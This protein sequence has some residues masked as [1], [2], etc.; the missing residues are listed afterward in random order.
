M[1]TKA[2]TYHQKEHWMLLKLL[3]VIFISVVPAGVLA[4]NINVCIDDDWFP[5]TFKKDGKAV[6]VHVDIVRKATEDLG[7]TVDLQPLPWKRCLKL[8]Q[9][10]KVD[11]V[12]SASYKDKRAAY[13]YYPNDVK[14]AKK[15]KG[16][17]DQV[18][19]VL[20]TRHNDPYEFNGDWST[21]PQPVGVG[22]LG[23]SITGTLEK[24]GLHVTE[25]N[26]KTG[27]LSMLVIKRV[28][29]VSLNPI[30]A[31]YFNTTGEFK[32]KLKI[33][34]TPLKSKSYHI[35]FSKKSALSQEKREQIWES[36]AT[37][38]SDNKFM[39]DIFNKYEK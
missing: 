29:A 9:L 22:G 31:N 5:Y 23:S 3:L 16:R 39:I 20:V 11:A 24:K 10:G 15:S 7:D 26:T 6:G 28:N 8:G 34:N 17:I 1:S 13:A 14:T 33:N 30:Q 27:V 21:I 35:I 25:N 38:R 19:Y 18:E 4:E 32:G 2:I 12:M 37:V 36:L